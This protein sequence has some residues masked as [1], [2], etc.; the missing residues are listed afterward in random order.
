MVP[1]KK[2]TAKEAAILRNL[3]YNRAADNPERKLERIMRQR[4]Q[5]AEWNH[6][7]E[8]DAITRTIIKE[9]A[10]RRC[11]KVTQNITMLRKFARWRAK[12]EDSEGMFALKTLARKRSKDPESSA[13]FKTRLKSVGAL[14]NVPAEEVLTKKEVNHAMSM[15]KDI[16]CWSRNYE[17]M[18]MPS[19]EV[20]KDKQG[21]VIV[22]VNGILRGR[23][24]SYS[25]LMSNVDG[26]DIIRGHRL[27]IYKPRKKSGKS[28]QL[29]TQEV[30]ESESDEMVPPTKSELDRLLNMT[31]TPPPSLNDTQQYIVGNF[32]GGC[33][34]LD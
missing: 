2:L 31:I 24:K 21:Y 1:K 17:T 11:R 3:A 34:S 7:D 19:V 30:T 26:D 14:K 18:V 12:P 33:P 5:R 15:R 28:M 20:S 8:K 13:L 9:E 27:S 25:D 16:G 6:M 4:A 23:Y 10:Q 29:T 22:K 32:T